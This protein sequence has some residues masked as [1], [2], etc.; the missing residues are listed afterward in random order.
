ME[1]LAAKNFVNPRLDAIARY[2]YR[3]FGDDLVNQGGNQQGATPASAIGNM[4]TGNL[5]QWHVG[6][7][8]SVPLGMRRA[9]LAVQI[10]ELML[11]RARTIQR[12]QQKKVVHDVVN[13][14]GDA[15]RA[16]LAAENNL[17]RFLAAKEVVDAYE[18]KDA[19]EIEQDAERVLDAQRRLMDAE[20]EYFRSRA[21][22]AVALKNV[23]F[24]KGS[25]MAY[26]NLNIYDGAAPLVTG[27]AI[28]EEP[29]TVVDETT[30]T[31]D[32]TDE[33]VVLP[34]VDATE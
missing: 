11:S 28:H 19:A 6:V 1:L 13:A 25:I 18:A 24:E 21:E 2:R 9:H 15:E 22:Y 17:N 31:H 3:G 14:I 29:V 8:F 5:Q 16:Y 10:A 4:F 33:S 20:T 32:G 23:H 27:P 26:N 7:E 34:P 30:T 12:E